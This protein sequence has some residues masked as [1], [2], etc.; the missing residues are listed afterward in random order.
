MI[1][2]SWLNNDGLL[3][4]TLSSTLLRERLTQDRAFSYN[5]SINQPI[6]Y[7]DVIGEKCR[8]FPDS[9]T[10][11]LLCWRLLFFIK[12]NNKTCVIV[13]KRGGAWEMD[14]EGKTDELA[15]GDQF[16]DWLPFS[17]CAACQCGNSC[18]VGILAK[19][20]KHGRRSL[21]LTLTR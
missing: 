21:V 6:R 15:G 8:R 11:T 14:F 16:P 9:H 18:L 19:R 10:R 3:P 7:L 4:N 5:Q 1:V 13:S 20:K 17:E 12:T 2:S